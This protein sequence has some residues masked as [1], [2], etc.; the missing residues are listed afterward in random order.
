MEKRTLVFWS[1]V[2]IALAVFL[3]WV[4]GVVQNLLEG[5]KPSS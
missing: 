5:F 2:L 1:A 4:S 3:W